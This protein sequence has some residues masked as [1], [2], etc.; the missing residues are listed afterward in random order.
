MQPTATVLFTA[1]CNV[2]LFFHAEF[3]LRYSHAS[4]TSSSLSLCSWW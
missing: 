1:A 2:V 4:S 3:D